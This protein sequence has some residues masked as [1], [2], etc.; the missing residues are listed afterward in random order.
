MNQNTTAQSVAALELANVRR[1]EMAAL[2]AAVRE[3]LPIRQALSDERAGSM[4]IG[5]LL[6]SQKSWGPVKVEELCNLVPIR[7][8]KRI[9]DLTDRQRERI[10]RLVGM[11][12]TERLRLVA[13]ERFEREFGRAA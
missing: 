10:G 6:A 9:R 1:L 8:N 2:R 4:Q 11:T 13:D 12:P 7:S 3:G 5:K